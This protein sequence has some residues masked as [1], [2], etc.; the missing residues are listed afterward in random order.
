MEDPNVA[1]GK[2]NAAQLGA[3]L[4]FSDESG[5]LL[6]PSVH[7]TW[8]PRGKTPIFY[9]SYRR[10]KISVISAISVSPKSRRLGLYFELCEENITRVEACDFVRNLLRHLRGPVILLWDNGRIHEGEEVEELLEDFPRLQL[11]TFPAYA[12]ELNPDENVWSWTKTRLANGRPEQIS[13]LRDSLL[14]TLGEMAGSQR[15][16]AGCLASTDL[17]FF[18]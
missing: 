17:S 11:L 8:A 1:A 2:K 12:P 9:H 10:D 4:V 16:L 18:D 3:H 13:D 14:D 7:K 6:V 5:F 15:L